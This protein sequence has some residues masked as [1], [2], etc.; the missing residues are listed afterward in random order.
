MEG[1]FNRKSKKP[2]NYTRNVRC[3][4]KY[5]VCGERNLDVGTLGSISNQKFGRDR[6]LGVLSTRMDGKD[7]YCICV[8]Q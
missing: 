1:E 7:R 5:D 6:I 8:L 2:V 4:W 3:P